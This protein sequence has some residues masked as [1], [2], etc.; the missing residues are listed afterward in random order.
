MR[1]RRRSG[2][3][4]NGRTDRRRIGWA[5]RSETHHRLAPR[6]MGFAI[7]LPIRARIAKRRQP[8]L[9]DVCRATENDPERP[10]RPCGRGSGVQRKAAARLNQVSPRNLSPSEN[11]PV[12]GILAWDALAQPQPEYVFDQQVQ[13]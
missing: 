1:A 8:L 2:E 6:A 12:N 9:F 4:S 13:W 10:V 11:P 3:S 5:G 7:A